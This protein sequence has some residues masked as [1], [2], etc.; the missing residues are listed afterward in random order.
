VTFH[1]HGRILVPVGFQVYFNNYDLV[2]GNDYNSLTPGNRALGIVQ[3]AQRCCVS[4][5]PIGTSRASSSARSFGLR[6]RR[7]IT[8]QAI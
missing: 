6:F 8:L 1:Q 4:I 5:R 3:C 2:G 7:S